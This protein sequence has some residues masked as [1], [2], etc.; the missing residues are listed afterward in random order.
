MSFWLNYSWLIVLI[1]IFILF[2]LFWLFDGGQPQ[3]FRG[4]Y[5]TPKSSIPKTPKTLKN[6]KSP[7]SSIPVTPNIMPKSPIDAL[8]E[9]MKDVSTPDLQKIRAKNTVQDFQQLVQKEFEQHEF[10]L[11]EFEQ[12]ENSKNNSD[13]KQKYNVYMGSDGLL[14]FHMQP[15][16]LDI[17]PV[18]EQ[19]DTLVDVKKVE[20]KL[21]DGSVRS[22]VITKRY[23]KESLGEA[24][25]RNIMEDIYG[26]EF[27]QI[28]P[29][30]LKY[31]NGKNLEIDCWCPKLKIGI[32]YNGAQ[33][34]KFV[35]RFHR[36][37]D[38]ASG[39]YVKQS[40]DKYK[41][42]AN[43]LE[44]MVSEKSAN[45]S[46]E[47]DNKNCQK[48]QAKLIE[49][50]QRDKWKINKMN[51][52]GYYLISVPYTVPHNMIRQYIEYYLPHNVMARQGKT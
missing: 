36:C 16:P 4:L 10:E 13:I 8:P 47:I 51:E 27:V 11:G 30:F 45:N 50:A 31:I 52:L 38:H 17:Q 46:N 39:K 25:S 48:C 33:H 35:P 3:E 37:K 19:D 32:E 2:F 23:P 29:N 20:E 15:L 5:Q 22:R 44:S 6:I 41:L 26:E 43:T 21:T 42:L 1:I 28:R 24:I 18:E 34:Y 9:L 14:K 7:I 12:K 49:Q 40:Q